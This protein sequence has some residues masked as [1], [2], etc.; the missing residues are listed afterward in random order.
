[1]PTIGDATTSVPHVDRIGLLRVATAFCR[2][3]AIAATCLFAY[4]TCESA[5]G[6]TESPQWAISE[7]TLPDLAHGAVLLVDFDGTV[8]YASPNIATFIGM[9]QVAATGRC[10]RPY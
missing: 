8:A 6:Q 10:Q 9:T 2:T 7:Q 5:V 3:R 4:F 1:M